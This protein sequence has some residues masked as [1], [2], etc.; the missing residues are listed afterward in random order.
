[1]ADISPSSH[2]SMEAMGSMAAMEMTS[3]EDMPS[4][5]TTSGTVFP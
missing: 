1:M 5:R 4:F 3:G 2:G